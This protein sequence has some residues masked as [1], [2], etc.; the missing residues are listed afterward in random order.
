[1]AFRLACADFTF[2]LLPHDDV[3]RLVA[4]LGFEGVD[5]GLFEGRSHLW[6]SREFAQL[7]ASAASLKQK[8]D[9]LGLAAADVFLQMDPDFTP[10]AI[11]HPDA[12]RRQHA[13]DWFL[14]TLDYAAA[15]GARHVTTLPGVEFPEESVAA[16]W[17]R[18][19]AELAWRVEQAR[20]HDLVF[21][22]EAHIGSLAPD[23]PRALKLAQDVPGLTLTVDY[24]HFAHQGLPDRAAEPMLAYASH[25]HVRG[26]APGRLQVAFKDNVI[27]YDRVLNVLRERHYQGWLGVEYIWSEWERCNECDNLSETILFR[28]YL[29]AR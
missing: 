15:A 28:D 26:A 9:N 25:F 12:D 20:R 27:N 21:G 18:A 23:P 16:F 7:D 2:P 22:V 6:P 10:W 17:D 4:M 1:M 14:R 24:T 5:I 3:L 11:N 29:R 8:L 13:R 19:V